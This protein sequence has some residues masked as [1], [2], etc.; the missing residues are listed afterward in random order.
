MAENVRHTRRN[1]GFTMG[2]IIATLAILAIVSAL[3][4]IAVGQ[5]MRSIYQQ[6]MDETAEEI[7]I[8]AQNH[9]TVAD[10]LGTLSGK[11]QGAIDGV[12]GEGSGIYYFVVPQNAAGLTSKSSMLYTMLP[13]LSI[14]GTVRDGGSYI[15]RYQYTQSAATVLDVFY[16]NPQGRYPYTFNEGGRDD[17]STLF[18]QSEYRSN[19]DEGKS[20][21]SNYNNAIIGY[22]GGANA[23]EG[24]DSLPTPVLEIYNAEIL[25]ARLTNPTAFSNCTF[26]FYAVGEESGAISEAIVP[27]GVDIKIDASGNRYYQAVFDSIT[28]FNTV[29]NYGLHF[30]ELETK[31]PA[32]PFIPG[33]NIS[34]QVFAISNDAPKVSKSAKQTTNS[35]F[36]SLGATNTDDLVE[37]FGATSSSS[38]ADSNIVKISSIRHLENLSKA[39]SGY[40]SYALESKL[41]FAADEHLSYEQAVDLSWSS[42]CKKIAGLEPDAAD[43]D[44]SRAVQIYSVDGSDPTSP[45]AFKPIDW[46]EG[47]L[48]YKGNARKISD[49]EIS[50]SGN[51]GLF[52][53]VSGASISDL[54]LAN[55]KVN[56]SSGN[57]GALAGD[58]ANS[59]LANVLVHDDSSSA[60][61]ASY[62][63][64]TDSGNAG[65]LVGN[66]TG[67]SIMRSAAAVI[68]RSGGQASGGLAGSA[69]G[70]SISNSYA[71]GHTSNGTYSDSSFNVSANEYAGGLLG[72][73]SSCAITGCY[74][75]CSASASTAGGLIGN[76]TGSSSLANAYATGLTGGNT[77]GAVVGNLGAG[78]TLTQTNGYYPAYLRSVDA[79]VTAVGSDENFANATIAESS[80]STYES[81]V[82]S[83][84][85]AAAP[86]DTWL[87]ETQQG[88]YPFKTIQQ[89]AGLTD[90]SLNTGYTDHIKRHYG[91]WPAVEI[92]LVNKR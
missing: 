69:S 64:A 29:G 51:A 52:G 44:A 31:D 14:D 68:V 32:K 38:G 91:D 62:G 17:F 49:V 43:N 90:D 11:T 58:L 15:I 53:S 86:Y 18:G 72:V 10:S 87:T 1:S 9:L 35:L 33:E 42:F 70:A 34:I 89:L 67:G 60:A 23:S 75:T 16:A 78:A 76:M 79:T 20:A 65:G 12:T 27:S 4:F 21:R 80:T 37:A 88:M 81:T 48:D 8:A 47:A 83:V 50:T 24:V 56:T 55:F 74:S 26:E 36:A 85:S 3:I 57:A 61:S 77:R 2:E 82:A 66:M 28:D 22:Y 30:S 73:A 63:V 59:T 7:Y 13:P 41:G 39:V 19:T 54:E 40:D 84:L 5:L 71:G 25:A 6:E 46:T 92:T 45:H